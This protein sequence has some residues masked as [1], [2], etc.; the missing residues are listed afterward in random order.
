MDIKIPNLGDGIDSATVISILVSPG[1]S[2]SK[3]QTLIEL[4]TDK[5]VAPV[6]APENGE[7]G[8]ITIKEGDVFDAR[9]KNHPSS[10]STRTPSISLSRPFSK[11]LQAII[12]CITSNLNRSS[13]L[14]L[15][16]SVRQTDVANDSKALVRSTEAA[17]SISRAPA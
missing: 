14:T 6:P 12:D 10:N 3:D 1:E 15:K 16:V 17:Y 7:I 9:T 5:A 2:V 13:T 4:E 8:S 11:S